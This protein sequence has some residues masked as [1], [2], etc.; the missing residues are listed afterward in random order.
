MRAG[1]KSVYLLNRRQVQTRG[2]WAAASF[3]LAVAWPRIAAAQ[4]PEDAGGPVRVGDRWVYDTKD[5]LTGY[6]KETYTEIVTDVSPKE[7]IV[8]FTVSGNP[9]SAA[10]TYDH[11]WNCIDNLV[12]KY[13]PSDGQG[14]RLPL[15][16]GKTW[17]TEFEAK[18]AQTGVNVKGSSLSKVVAQEPVTT[19]AGTFDTFKIERQVKQ[20]NTADPSKLTEVQVVI[21]YAPQINHFVRRTT[22][23]KFE[24][25]TRSN[26]SE[27]LADFSRNL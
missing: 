2:L 24:K 27:E 19:T 10:I 1:P 22:L 13:K 8:N 11:D 16:V 23:V 4:S 17:R 26:K 12:W 21:W 3:G 9:I 6:S 20:F 7:T 25:R 15:A 5:E 18:H 14:I